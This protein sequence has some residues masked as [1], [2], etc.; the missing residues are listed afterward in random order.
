MARVEVWRQLIGVGS[1]Q[2]PRG[3]LGTEPGVRLGNPMSHFTTLGFVCLKSLV[4][5]KLGGDGE[6]K[7]ESGRS[8]G[9]EWWW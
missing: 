6:V 5:K 3:V 9:E 4:H 7:G 1:F 8:Y 2:L